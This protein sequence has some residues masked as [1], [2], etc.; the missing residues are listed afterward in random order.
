[1][2]V[3]F[4][5]LKFL[6]NPF[7]GV[8]LLLVLFQARLLTAQEFI[9]KNTIYLIGQ[10]TN[11]LNGGPIK[12]Q[13]I[14]IQSD[15]TYQVGFHYQNIV[16]TDI[17]GYFYDTITTAYNKG[18]LVVSTTD[19][20]GNDQDTTVYCR[21]T[22]SEANV[23]FVNFSLPTVPP[24]VFYQANFYYLRNPSGQ[25][26]SE[27]QFY[28]LTNSGNVLSYVWDF[29]DGLSSSESNPIHEYLQSGIYRVMLTVVIQPDPYAQPI[30]SSI[31]KVINVAAKD[32]FYIGGHVMAG[33]FPIDHGE[34]YLYK[35][36]SNELVPIDT[37]VFNDSLGFYLFYQVIE[38]D[39]LVKA[40][41]CPNSIHFNHF[42]TTYYS[43]KL[44]WT[45]AD[46]IFHTGNN[47]EYNIELIPVTQSFSGQGSISGSIFYGFDSK[48]GGNVPACNVEILLFNENL[49]PSICTHSNDNGEFEFQ[50]L[51]TGNYYI[52]AEVTGKYT[53]PLMVSLDDSYTE[54]TGIALTIGSLA[55]YGSMIG[56]TENE[57]TNLIGQPYPNPASES[58]CI[59][60]QKNELPINSIS[61][62]SI[63]GQLIKE[64]NPSS[65]KVFD[66]I[67][68]DTEYIN[69][70]I[71]FVR[72][73]IQNQLVLRKLIKK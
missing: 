46:T 19:Y 68:L 2:K 20:L 51:D 7:L 34:A 31:V 53:Y 12:E 5:I 72:I 62:L 14:T 66:H 13:E 43:N 55:V 24:Q 27:Y 63:T 50:N 16:F 21:F 9:E 70:G 65:C 52:H 36:E 42:F 40:D 45:D 29:G 64:Y 37:A 54:I 28:D 4:K 59:E 18:G 69:P 41:L 22:W 67:I 23:L 73:D 35:I 39:Y 30:V 60:L 71:Y 15:T 33:Y 17:E 25:N 57:L 10:V 8:L 49:E 61:L 32:Y 26:P 6:L 1:M 48:E 58:A 3:N 38:G 44:E 47:C 56:V 11:Q